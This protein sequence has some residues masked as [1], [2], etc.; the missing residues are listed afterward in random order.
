MLV[1]L[2]QRLNEITGGG[3]N[4]CTREAVSESRSSSAT[5]AAPVEEAEASKPGGGSAA[6]TITAKKDTNRAWE[7]I[8][9]KGKAKD[10]D[11]LIALLDE[12]GYES[13]ADLEL[14]TP[15]DVDSIKALLKPVGVR[16]FN[17]ALLLE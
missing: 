15:E 2:N 3:G 6:A 16:A 11:V 5:S 8:Q 14:I 13:A 7:I 4:F 9:S 1:M 10:Y 12:L 17:A